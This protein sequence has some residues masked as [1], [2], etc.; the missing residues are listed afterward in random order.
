MAL[1]SINHGFPFPAWPTSASGVP[2]TSGAFAIDAAAEKAASIWVA[3]AAKAIRTIHIRTATVATGDTVDVRVET[4]DSAA[5]GDPTGTLHTTNSNASL[6]IGSGDDNVWK[7]VQLTADTATLAI[8]D[9]FACVVV[10]GGGGGNI[11]IAGYQDQSVAGIPYGDLFTASWAKNSNAAL[12]IPQYS[13]GSFEPIFGFADTGGPINTTTFNSGTATNRRGNIFQVPFPCRAKGAWAWVDA[14]GDFTI[15]LYD[16]DGTTV[17]ATTANV[18][19]FQRQGAAGALSF[20]PFTAAAT[21]AANTSYRIVVVPADTT[22]LSTYDFDVPAAAMLDM[23]PGGQNCH[24]SVF[25]SSAWVETTTRRG[26]L[27]VFLDAFS[28]GI[29]AGGGASQLVNSGALIG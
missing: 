24:A 20:V 18:N 19:R 29:G 25:T 13:D 23:F 1:Q 10:N 26:Y 27:G 5:N 7:S 28:D 9:V 2:S 3:S 17:L 11:Q 12:I 6:A 14:D 16:S 8:G 4:V 21:L 15:K 22:N